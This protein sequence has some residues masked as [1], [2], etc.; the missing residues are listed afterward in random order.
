MNRLVWFALLLV[1]LLSSSCVSIFANVTHI[2]T[3]GEKLPLGALVSIRHTNTP[4][5][6]IRVSVR[7]G[8]LDIAPHPHIARV[9]RSDRDRVLFITVQHNQ[10]G[11]YDPRELLSTLTYVA[12]PEA[13]KDVADFIVMDNESS[14]RTVITMDIQR[15]IKVNQPPVNILPGDQTIEAGRQL[16]LNFNV[17]D[18]DIGLGFFDIVLSVEHGEIR[19]PIGAQGNGDIVQATSKY[20][21]L[22]TTAERLQ[23]YLSGVIY[24]APFSPVVDTLT[25][26]SNDRGNNG[27]D[28]QKT[29]KKTLSINVITP[30]EPT[31]PPFI[32]EVNAPD[33]ALQRAPLALGTSSIACVDDKTC[34]GSLFASG[35]TAPYTFSTISS[36][37]PFVSVNPDGS[38]SF[39]VPEISGSSPFSWRVQITDSAGNITTGEV[40]VIVSNS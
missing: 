31:V 16:S 34:S 26:S 14:A 1:T 17:Q 9:I 35:G 15:P 25:F 12:D 6:V 10:P 38:Y 8:A 7:E 30:I 24:T 40:V 21:Y 20:I 28:G 2:T 39:Y 37:A 3:T 22:K 32:P 5:F 4:V 23:S 27:D 11:E 29:D 19:L 18:P 33:N 13:T 36:T